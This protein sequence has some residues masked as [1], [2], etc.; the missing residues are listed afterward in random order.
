V[1]AIVKE[2]Q[3]QK[4]AAKLLVLGIFP[5][6]ASGKALIRAKIRDTNQRLAR[7]ADG[8]RVFYLDI[9]ARFLTADGALTREIMYDALHL[10]PKGYAIWADAI[11]PTLAKLLA[12][13]AH[14]PLAE[15]SAY[16]ALSE[17]RHGIFLGGVGSVAVPRL[18]G[19]ARMMDRMLTGRVSGAEEGAALGLAQYVVED[20][21]GLAR[22]I[23]LAE[24]M[25]SK[26]VLSSF[27][28]LPALPRITPVEPETELLLES[29]MAGKR[30]RPGRQ[31]PR[32]G[33]AWLPGG[34]ARLRAVG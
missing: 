17:G 32:P 10:T 4:P 34:A 20:S 27:A 15:R 23:E 21:H 30:L 33:A 5:R 14:I 11:K 31:L 19:T 6:S 18:I 7:L 25:A 3:R 16:Y 24:R 2:L 29:P 26:A 13:A 12:A 22:G 28:V 9:G 1:A 8:E